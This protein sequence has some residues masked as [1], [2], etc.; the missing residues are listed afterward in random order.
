MKRAL[1]NQ[2]RTI[3]LPVHAVGKVASIRR[4]ET[5]LHETLGREPTDEELANHLGF[6]DARR[7]RR[8][9]DASKRPMELDA[10]IGPE[11]DSE[12]VSDVVADPNAVAPFAQL[13]KENDRS[14]IREAIKTLEDRERII[15][16]M[17]FGLDDTGPK[18]LDKIGK[19]FGVTRERI[20]QLE[21]LALQKMRAAMEKRDF[22]FLEN[23][24]TCSV[25]A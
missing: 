15:L 22:L 13:I 5:K 23:R 2:S 1:A 14:L 10:P 24:E 9:R 25:A 6:D 12:Q 16:I 21:G 18:T 19:K 17:R 11:S 20:R 8:Y 4:A 7:V 3:R